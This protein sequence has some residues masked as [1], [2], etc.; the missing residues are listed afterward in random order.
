MKI[1]SVAAAIAGT[2]FLLW[3]AAPVE[4]A[5]LTG[6]DAQA[7][8]ELAAR[9]DGAKPEGEVHILPVPISVKDGVALMSQRDELLRTYTQGGYER[10]RPAGRLDMERCTYLPLQRVEVHRE[11]S[12]YQIVDREAYV[13]AK[14]GT[15]QLIGTLAGAGT[16]LAVGG[17]LALL[18]GFNPIVLLAVVGMVGAFAGLA[19]GHTVAKKAAE[20]KPESF[21]EVREYRRTEN[22]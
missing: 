10:C 1:L 2:P 13:K 9:Y 21:T 5:A 14:S 4:P 11:T 20:K 15:G 3:A 16:G 12:D 19:I 6:P 18:T 22:I 7:A 8:H 17:L